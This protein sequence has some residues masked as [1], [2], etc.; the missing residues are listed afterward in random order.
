M[1]GRQAL[2]VSQ[3][4]KEARSEAVQLCRLQMTRIAFPLQIHSDNVKWVSG[5]GIFADV[6]GLITQSAEVVLALQ[7]A[8]CVPVFIYDRQKNTRGLIHAGWRGTTGSITARLVK[9]LVN[10]G[11]D[12]HDLIVYLGPAIC[13][14]HYEVGEEVAKL[15]H[16]SSLS[17]NTSRFYADL[18]HEL[19]IKFLELGIPG[20]NIH[21]SELCTYEDTRCCSYRRDGAAAGR[22]FAFIEDA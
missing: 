15:F 6:D 8:D 19:T 18:R 10:E 7:V 16:E 3:S 21:V 5:S 9:S 13:K 14:E 12:T 20:E 2:A 11:T 17:E 22:M 4:P 1:I